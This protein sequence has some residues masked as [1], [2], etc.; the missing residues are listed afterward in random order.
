MQNTRCN[1]GIKIKQWRKNLFLLSLL[2]LC[3]QF[4]ISCGFQLSKESEVPNEFKIIRFYPND[5]YGPI[6]RELRSIFVANHVEIINQST[7]YT[8]EEKKQYPAIYILSTS[9]S[10]NV[11]SIFP[12]GASAESQMRFSVEGKV[13]KNGHVYPVTATIFRNFF[14]NPATAL[15]KSTEE[16]LIQD[17][18]YQQAAQLF[19]Q[20]LYTV[21]T[22]DD[23]IEQEQKN[24]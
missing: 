6:T 9:S 15:A 22:V 1:D 12:N 7:K 13:I 4:L 19:V 10:T 11:T 3:S 16:D 17:E 5:E 21:S 23:K 14:D 24:K 20:K 2:C 8:E 18:M